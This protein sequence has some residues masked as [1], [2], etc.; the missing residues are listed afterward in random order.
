MLCNNKEAAL[1]NAD[2]L[3]IMS[4]WKEFKQFPFEQLLSSL[5]N[6]LLFD[7]RNI[8]HPAILELK[9]TNYFA[10]VFI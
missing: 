3:I 7:G 8:L 6:P 10:V 9:R 4:G 1:I 5:T 2:A